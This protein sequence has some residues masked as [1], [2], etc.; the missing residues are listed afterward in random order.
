MAER[1][2]NRSIGHVVQHGDTVESLAATYYGDRAQG[3]FIRELNQAGPRLSVGRR[4]RIPT[5]IVVKLKPGETLEMLAK[6]LLGDGR[7]AHFLAEWNGLRDGDRPAAGTPVVVP[8]H[9]VHRAP[10]PESLATLAKAFYGDAAQGKLL[11]AYNFRTA[12]L[13]GRGERVIIPVPHVRIKPAVLA[14]LERR[15]ARVSTSSISPTSPIAATARPESPPNEAAPGLT[16]ASLSSSM[17]AGAMPSIAPTPATVTPTTPSPTAATTAKDAPPANVGRIAERLKQAERAFR[18]GSYEDAQAQ[19]A[20]LLDDGGATSPQL[21]AIHRLLGFVYAS[22]GSDEDAIRE[23]RDVLHRDPAL[24]LDE[25][26]VS[27]RIRAVF[28]RARASR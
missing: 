20:R 3:L 21:L 22:V 15:Q 7:R 5:A 2:G 4:V 13:V 6:R 26:Q 19:L 9:L 24:V 27:P 11:G 23:F 1:S 14:L 16:R 18:E 8:F 17:L 10:A 28:E 25:V 12:P